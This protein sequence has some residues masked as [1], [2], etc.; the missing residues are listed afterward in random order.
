M[1]GTSCF[2]YYFVDRLTNK[3]KRQC[4]LVVIRI[5]QIINSDLRMAFGC[6]EKSIGSFYFLNGYRE[7]HTPT[8]FVSKNKTIGVRTN[9]GNKSLF[10]RHILNNRNNLNR[11]I[12]WLRLRKCRLLCQRKISRCVAKMNFDV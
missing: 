6:V 5:E 11:T 9:F 3:N 2:Y 7:V 8:A 1:C 4:R 12:V 10:S